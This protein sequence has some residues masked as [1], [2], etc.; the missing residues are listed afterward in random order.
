MANILFGNEKGAA[1][2]LVLDGSS[3]RLYHATH[4]KAIVI[5]CAT[6]LLLLK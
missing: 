4:Q 2:R 5:A 6:A 3:H 1:A